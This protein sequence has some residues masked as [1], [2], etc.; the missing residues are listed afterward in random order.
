MLP[1]VLTWATGPLSTKEC[2]AHVTCCQG[3]GHVARH[4]TGHVARHVTGHVARHADGSRRRHVILLQL[5][6]NIISNICNIPFAVAPTSSFA[7][8]YLAGFSV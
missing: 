2:R 1:E 3:N 6:I 8:V 5:Y 7:T 4:V